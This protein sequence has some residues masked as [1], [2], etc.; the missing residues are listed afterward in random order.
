MGKGLFKV[1]VN[2]EDVLA[3]VIDIYAITDGF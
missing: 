2:Q 1:Q 3:H